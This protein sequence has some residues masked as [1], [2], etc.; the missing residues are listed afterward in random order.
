MS[1]L[2]NPF[3]AFGVSS[4]TSDFEL[5]ADAGLGL[6]D[7]DPVATWNDQS[8]SGNHAT[9]STSGNKPTFKATAGPGGRPCV[10]FDGGDF[11]S[12]TNLITGQLYTVFAV[13]NVAD[14]N[15]RTICGDGSGAFQYRIYQLKQEGLRSRVAVI[16]TSTT[17][18]STGTWYQVAMTYNG[19]TGA[20][21]F[22]LSGSADGSGTNNVF[23]SANMGE[24][25]RNGNTFSEYWQTDLAMV[26][27]HKRILDSSEL[28]A[29][30]A[31][32][33]SRWGVT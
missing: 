14:S 16:G 2:L 6:S 27:L 24:I 1:Y 33:S 19:N 17:A 9:Q 12:L 15:P 21:A 11:L 31:A 22:Y 5:Q 13:I 10:R 26:K 4:P 30:F 8:G 3:G 20:Y 18:I 7:N 32:I 25:G 29:E 28:S 23:L